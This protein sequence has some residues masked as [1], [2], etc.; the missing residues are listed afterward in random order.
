MSTLVKSK[1]NGFPSLKSRMED[2]WNTDTLFDKPFF[3]GETLPAVNIKD[4]KNHDEVEV[5]A[6]GFKKDDFKITT[7]NGLL[8][9]SAE[10]SSEKNEEKENYTRREFSRSS[11]TRTFSLPDDVQEDD[12][13]AKYRDGL[14]TI[15]LKKS[16]K[17]A[18]NKKEV[19]VD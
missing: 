5:A 14:L 6:P 16:A 17:T 8:T 18:V 10:T 1:T 13:N 9:I 2:L 12:V 7:E 3:S 11:F 15:D 19:K 4:A